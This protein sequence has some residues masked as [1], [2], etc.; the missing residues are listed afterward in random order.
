MPVDMFMMSQSDQIAMIQSLKQAVKNDL[1]PFSDANVCLSECPFEQIALVKAGSRMKMSV[2]SCSVGVCCAGKDT[3]KPI[4]TFS[5][6]GIYGGALVPKLGPF[7]AEYANNLETIEC[8][9]SGI[10]PDEHV[11]LKRNGDF[12]AEIVGS[13]KASIIRTD[14][15]E[16]SFLSALIPRLEIDGLGSV[17]LGVQARWAGFWEF[18][19]SLVVHWKERKAAWYDHALLGQEYNWLWRPAMAVENIDDRDMRTTLIFLAILRYAQ[20]DAVGM[21]LSG[22]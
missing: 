6:C 7:Y 17:D 8:E 14:N 20:H 9:G 19:S 11:L 2:G 13:P 18:L 15:S 3:F 16:L 12:L 5:H 22:R 1:N 21:V 4:G 10:G